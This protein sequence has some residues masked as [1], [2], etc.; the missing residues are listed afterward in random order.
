MRSRSAENDGN[1]L[2][3]RA[4]RGCITLV[5]RLARNGDASAKCELVLRYQGGKYHQGR[6]KAV[7]EEE[8]GGFTAGSDHLV[9]PAEE[10]VSSRDL[11]GGDVRLE[12]KM[13]RDAGD[14]SVKN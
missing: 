13:K 6:G 7:R 5:V 3:A 1:L 14:A 10:N 12:T 9:A 4:A 8:E 11:K 2:E